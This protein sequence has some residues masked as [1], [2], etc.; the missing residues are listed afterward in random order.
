MDELRMANLERLVTE[1]DHFL[2]G[3]KEA[4]AL[5]ATE[6]RD[7]SW[8]L[9]VSDDRLFAWLETY[10]PVGAGIPL[11]AAEII[12]ALEEAGLCL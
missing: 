12:E 5:P 10:P 11:D 8:E 7:A 2:S 9:R 1:I 6:N 4:G 3:T